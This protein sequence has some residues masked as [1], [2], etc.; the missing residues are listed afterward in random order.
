MTLS[1][2]FVISNL[3]DKVKSLKATCSVCQLNK[4]DNV[5]LGKLHGQLTAESPFERI[6]IDLLGPLDRTVFLN[7]QDEGKVVLLVIIDI[8][9][10]WIKI[11]PLKK[12]T[13]KKVIKALRANGLIDMAIPKVF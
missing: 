13:T 8:F 7:E 2:G 9:S 12:I 1:G 10:K 5:K 11:I 3:F 4:T 6:A